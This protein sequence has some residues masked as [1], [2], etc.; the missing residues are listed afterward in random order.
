MWVTLIKA[1][2]FKLL[3]MQWKPYCW[4]KWIGNKMHFP[5]LQ[6]KAGLS[7]AWKVHMVQIIPVI[8]DKSSH[9]DQ[10]IVV[11]LNI[12][13]KA[14]EMKYNEH[15]QWN[16]IWSWIL[17]LQELISAKANIL[18]DMSNGDLD[19][20]RPTFETDYFSIL[21]NCHGWTLIYIDAH[22]WYVY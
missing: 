14:I 11:L 13:S 5:L 18:M 2:E 15:V 22:Q 7:T 1:H 20:I 17:N 4:F 19:I 16:P 3:R 21:Q 6:K 10:R 12:D 9:E 8:T